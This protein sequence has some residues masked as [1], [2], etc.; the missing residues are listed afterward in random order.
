MRKVLLS[1]VLF[2]QTLLGSGQTHTSYESLMGT[3][4]LY[5]T[6]DYL[7]NELA[8]GRATGSAGK[9]SAEQFIRERFRSYGLKPFNWNYTQS[10]PYNDTTIVR[11]VVGVVPANSMSDEYI[12]V[13]AHY[14][15]LGRL[16][17]QIYS[18]ADDNASG[19]TALLAIARVFAKMRS[20]DAGP[21][22]NIIF[23]A[24][25]GKELDLI[26]SEYFVKHLPFPAEKVVCAVNIDMLGTTLA[27][28]HRNRPDYLIVLGEETLPA[29]MQGIIRRC[30]ANSRFGMDIDY[31]FYG[32]ANFTDMVY[33]T[34]DQYSFRQKKIPS[35]LFTSA[36]HDHTYKPTDKIDII[37]F[38]MLH[39]R[40]ALIFDVLYRY[41]NL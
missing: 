40:T 31:T 17:G 19:V 28:I 16:G 13:G 37:D 41:S 10:F 11:N 14:D 1:I 3:E 9:L 15:H 18:G 25:D 26:G 12:I 34:G 33:R 21:A 27:P 36:F 35:L 23:V 20:D 2:V 32:S 30:N 24:Y 5:Q 8:E 38:A 4:E 7:A 6:L 22:K 39:K 29:G